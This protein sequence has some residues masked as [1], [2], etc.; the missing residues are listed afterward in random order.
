MGVF[1]FETIA[2]ALCWGLCW[3]IG[4][5]LSRR[6]RRRPP[7]PRAPVRDLP[8]NVIDLAEYRRRR[9]ARGGMAVDRKVRALPSSRG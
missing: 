5:V 9:A 3:W 7:P 6:E 4:G 8:P 2:F 1:F